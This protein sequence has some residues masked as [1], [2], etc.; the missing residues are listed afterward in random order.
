M[1]LGQNNSNLELKNISNKSKFVQLIAFRNW[2][3]I[4]IQCSIILF[5]AKKKKKNFNLIKQ[6]SIRYI[7]NQKIVKTKHITTPS[8]EFI[9]FSNELTI[10]QRLVKRKCI[11]IIAPYRYIERKKNSLGLCN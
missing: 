7:A 4:K 11:K 5:V 10:T 2:E 6:K 1:F 9:F 8:K 3:I